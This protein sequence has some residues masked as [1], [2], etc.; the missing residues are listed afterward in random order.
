M[1]AISAVLFAARFVFGHEQFEPAL[2]GIG[3]LCFAAQRAIE[4]GI[5][6]REGEDE[7]FDGETNFFRSDF[8]RW[9]IDKGGNGNADTIRSKHLY[10]SDHGEPWELDSGQVDQK[11][12]YLS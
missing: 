8:W 1:K 11:R 7:G 10:R 2:F 9:I 4:F 3:Q 5:K 12:A 6:G